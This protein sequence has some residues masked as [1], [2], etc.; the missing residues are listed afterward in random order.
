MDIFNSTT[1]FRP[2][3]FGAVR[4]FLFSHFFLMCIYYQFSTDL[5][6]DYSFLKGTSVIAV[7]SVRLVGNAPFASLN[8]KRLV[9]S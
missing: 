5:I 9:V 3:R 1:T 7:T 6:V 2:G 4:G 8:T